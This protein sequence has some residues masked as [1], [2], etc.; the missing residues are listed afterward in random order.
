VVDDTTRPGHKARWVFSPTT[1][2]SSDDSSLTCDPKGSL[3]SPPLRL[4]DPK[5]RISITLKDVYVERKEHRSLLDHISNA[6][7]FVASV[8]TKCGPAFES[9]GLFSS[10]RSNDRI[11]AAKSVVDMFNSHPQSDSTDRKE[12]ALL[13][14]SDIRWLP[15]DEK[16]PNGDVAPVPHYVVIAPTASLKA[17]DL[18]DGFATLGPVK[19]LMADASAGPVMVL[20]FDP[21]ETVL[22]N[23]VS[24]ILNQLDAGDGLRQ[25]FRGIRS[26]ALARDAAKLQSLRATAQTEAEARVDG[27]KFLDRE[28]DTVDDAFVAEVALRLGSTAQAAEV[29]AVPESVVVLARQRSRPTSD[30]AVV[31]RIAQVAQPE[32]TMGALGLGDGGTRGEL[33]GASWESTAKALDLV[34]PPGPEQQLDREAAEVLYW[35]TKAGIQDPE[36]EMRLRPYAARR[37]ARDVARARGQEVGFATPE[38]P[39]PSR[40]TAETP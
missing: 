18:A 15:G 17:A 4:V 40:A 20:A 6:L 2:L 12:V 10:L 27:G 7:G 35:L 19:D 5:V 38:A 36:R 28:V 39:P 25:A 26:A 14:L 1:P 11:G 3:L 34:D 9:L 22:P 29:L 8:M 32:A 21:V 33:G 24:T 16:L 13:Q 37:Y 30:V 31:E 23:T